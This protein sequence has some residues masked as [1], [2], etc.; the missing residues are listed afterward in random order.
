MKKGTGY[1]KNKF[2]G[3]LEGAKT[4]G[5]SCLTKPELLDVDKENFWSKL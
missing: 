2:K 3:F 5:V 1:Q 4:T